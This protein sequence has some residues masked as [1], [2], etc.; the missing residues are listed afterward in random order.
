[1]R[2]D[3]NK[4]MRI[5]SC[6]FWFAQLVSGANSWTWKD[7]EGRVRTQADLDRIIQS[8]ALWIETDQEKGQMATFIG[9]DLA[10][11]KLSGKNLRSS[12]YSNTTAVGAQFDG[13]DLTGASLFSVVFSGAAFNRADLKNA[14]VF[15]SDLSGADLTEADLTNAVL[16]DTSLRRSVLIRT[17][18]AGAQIDGSA[19]L[20][21]A[22]YEPKQNPAPENIAMAKGLGTLKWKVNSGPIYALRKSFLEAGFTA[23]A[24]QLTAAIH[25]H[26]QKPLEKFLFDWTCEW[27]ANWLRPLKIGCLLCVFCTFVYWVGMHFATRSGLYLTATGQRITTSAGKEHTFKIDLGSVRPSTSSDQL[28]LDFPPERQIVTHE[29]GPR[30]RLMAREL[31]GLGTAFLFSLMSVFNIGFREFNFGRWIRTLQPREFDIR[32]RGWMRSVSGVQS[33]LGVALLALS[34]LSYF[35]HPFD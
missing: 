14:D 17:N 26:D 28:E 25:R 32:A 15:G 19:D 30:R 11:V 12:R 18:L 4:E 33:L 1:M 3:S 6:I 13:A 31:N 27:G 2:D 22:D 35:G 16:T 7:Y 9:G 8:H 29:R 34:L 5:L 24:R 20:E 10:G 21:E 23:P